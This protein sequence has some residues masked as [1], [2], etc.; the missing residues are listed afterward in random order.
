MSGADAKITASTD[1][2]SAFQYIKKQLKKQK[3][4]TKQTTRHQQHN[5]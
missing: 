2:R 1:M 3:M 5:N 4:F